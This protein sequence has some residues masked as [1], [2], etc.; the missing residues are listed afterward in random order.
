[1]DSNKFYLYGASGHC[2]VV[3][4]LIKLNKGNIDFIVDDDLSKKRFLDYHVNP[5]ELVSKISQN[6][7]ISIGNNHIRQGIA[8]S[9]HIN[10]FTSIC[11]PQSIIDDSVKIE[12]GTVIM[13][14][15][16]INSS[17]MIGKHCI[18]NTSSSIDHDCTVNDYVHI[19]PN[20]TLCGNVVIGKL[21]HIGAGSVIIQG[22]RIGANVTVGA[23]SVIISDIPDNSVVVGNPGKIIKVKQ[24]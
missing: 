19:A 18:I 5:P 24:Q 17:S 23:G 16:V 20:A 2:K 7:I 12:E 10:K 6:L 1:M 3:I 9:I 13:A 4:D 11:H 21:S 14:G 15:V 22:M 8:D